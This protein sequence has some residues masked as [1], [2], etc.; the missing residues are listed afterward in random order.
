MREP[1][2]LWRMLPAGDWGGMENIC[3]IGLLGKSDRLPSGT[4]TKGGEGEGEEG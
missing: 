3:G 1:A 2:L 4:C